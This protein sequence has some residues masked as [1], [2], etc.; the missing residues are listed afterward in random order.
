MHY[1]INLSANLAPDAPEGD[2]DP[3]LWVAVNIELRR[4]LAEV[5]C[6]L[7]PSGGHVAYGNRIA[8]F[9]ASCPEEVSLL[10]RAIG[11]EEPYFPLEP[12]TGVDSP[13]I[14]VTVNG[15]PHL[16]HVGLCCWI[17]EDARVFTLCDNSGLL[18]TTAWSMPS[19]LQPDSAGELMDVD[20]IVKASEH[21]PR[22][23]LSRHLRDLAGCIES[24]APGAP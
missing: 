13:P 1:V 3:A 2:D 19:E 15:I 5:G 18:G 12:I 23:M 6:K 11:I 9:E 24:D 16:V 7:T 21:L 14:P 17:C 10:M 22:A 8:Y 20:V 4:R